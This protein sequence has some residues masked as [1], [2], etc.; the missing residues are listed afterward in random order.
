ML[1]RRTDL[2]VEAKA[3]WEESARE[4]TRLPG[5][6]AREGSREGFPVTT[7]DILDQE[8]EQAL[9]KPAGRYITLELT[10]LRRRE[11]DAFGRAARALSAELASLLPLAPGDGVLV[12]GLGNR[13]ITPDA[14]GPRAAD[15][16][17]VTRHLVERG[18]PP[19]DG[20]R[21]VSALA[22]GVLGTT[23][24]ESGELV[25][26]V[27]ARI[28]PACVL[29]VDALASRSLDRVCR[30]IQIADTGI[31][32]GSGVGN[33]RAALNRETLGV[34][35]IAIGVPTVVDAATLAADLLAEAGRGELD[36]AALSGHGA[37]VIVTPREIDT[38]VADLAKVI[39]YGINLA[40]HTG[41]SV[42]DI[43]ML[44]G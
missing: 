22:A 12:A 41:L 34:P 6:A 16:T 10:G 29:A 38:D 15:H 43:D 1:K 7:V 32:P 42:A 3:L 14:V 4:K 2:A 28:H 20:F 27:A 30:T 44:L 17:L 26:A 23:G 8:G 40:L 39:G 18:D 31:V 33:A 9:G 5:V 36:P 25:A 35:V 13:A 37:G 19:F 21:P 11:E 24:V